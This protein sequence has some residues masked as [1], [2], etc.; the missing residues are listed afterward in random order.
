MKRPE[1]HGAYCRTDDE[2]HA[3]ADLSERDGGFSGAFVG[4][5]RPPNEADD[6]E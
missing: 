5:A 2:T 6:A 1:Q 3:E 4:H